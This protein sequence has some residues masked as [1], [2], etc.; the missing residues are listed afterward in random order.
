VSVRVP[1]GCRPLAGLRWYKRL[2]AALLAHGSEAYAKSVE[3]RKERLLG[4][5]A[6]DVVELGPGPGTNLRFYGPDVRWLGI[7]PNAYMRP[8]LEREARRLGRTVDLRIGVAESLPLA[9]A[10]AD[11]V[12]ASLVLC[13][14][15]DVSG[16]LREVRRVLRPGGRFVFIEHVGAPAGSWTR[17]LQRALRPVWMVLGDGCHPDR[18]TEAAIAAAGF[19]RVEAE[20]FRVPFPVI[21]PHIS[22][23]ASSPSADVPGRPPASPAGP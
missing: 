9:D 10:S 18:D 3:A 22:G 1:A 4:P 17:R 13:T 14:V 15:H 11:A 20:S 12:V 19:A 5:L 2:H 23:T 6:G 21:G 7:E 16:A 8:H